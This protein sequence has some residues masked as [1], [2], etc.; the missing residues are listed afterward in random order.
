MPEQVRVIAKNGLRLRD[1]PRDG[2]TLRVLERGARLEELGRETWVRVRHGDQVGFVLAD[3]VEPATAAD[4]TPEPA[5]PPS[6][7]VPVVD[8]RIIQIIEYPE[9]ETVRGSA[10]VRI[11]REFEP[12]M[13]GIRDLAKAHGLTVWVT[14][15]LRE[16]YKPVPGAIVEPAKF[17]N[18]HIGHGI[19]MNLILG[20]QWF[21]STQLGNFEALPQPIQD[22]L[23]GVQ[24]DLKLRWGGKFST[25]D[26]VHIDDG[27]NLNDRDRFNE[28]LVALWGPAQV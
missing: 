24:R 23:D 12:S 1:S 25:P 8:P 26:P 5:V 7:V 27:L 9:S 11:D 19:D 3:F 20:Q 4:G 6:P 18:H 17:S 16:P 15:S 2:I 21:R 22:F 14:S 10:P 13:D 28:K